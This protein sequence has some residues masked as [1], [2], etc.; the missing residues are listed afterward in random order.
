MAHY[1]KVTIFGGTGF[2][3]R[4]VVDK[5][6]DQNVIVRVATRSPSS[7]Y[8]LRTAGS[9]GQIVPF[10]CNIHDELSVEEAVQGSDWVINLV[11][12]LSES[13][14]QNFDE[15]HHLFPE[16][17]AKAA[18]KAGV[19][20]LVHISALGAD[21]ASGSH[22]AQSKAQGEQAILNAFPQATI[23]RPS[24]VFG[25]E[26]RFFNKFAAMAEVAPFLP[27]I[28]GGKTRFQPVYV[29]DVAQAIIQS[30]KLPHE[31][32]QGRVYELA[33][34]ETYSFRQLLEKV[35]ALTGRVR[36]FLTIPFGL[37][38]LQGAIFQMLPGKVL[39]VDQV[40]LLRQDNVVSGS[41]SGLRNL[42]ITPETLDAILPS[43]LSRY[44]AGGRF[45]GK[46][47]AA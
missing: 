47:H 32:V 34:D 5:L 21:A 13:G 37:A 45:A 22:Y 1:S 46:R 10:H 8:F 20:R 15:M 25:P 31:E 40:R 28:G 38:M 12:V 16:R 41:V 23:L 2:I 36:R 7:A 44:R 26:D 30:L 39:T 33:G 4:Y 14:Q 43:Y 3:G 6:A 35:S 11:G 24:I 19:K 27:L 9:T 17:L 18:Q 42:G 29:G